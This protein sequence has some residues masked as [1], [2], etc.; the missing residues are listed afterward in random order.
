MKTYTHQFQV[1]ATLESVLDFH[2]DSRALKQLTPPPLFVTFK[3][4]EPLAEGSVADFTMWFGPIPIRWV[5]KHSDVDPE[6][7]FTDEQIQGPFK[8]WVHQHSFQPI[9]ESRTIVIDRV[10]AEPGDHPF[11]GLVSRFMWITMPI[12]FAYRAWRTRRALEK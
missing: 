9:D 7:G 12:L 10:Q 6:R 5:A 4:V 8:A 3:K 2:R 1:N 11:W